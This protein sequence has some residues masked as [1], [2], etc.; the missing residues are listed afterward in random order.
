MIY[1]VPIGVIKDTVTKMYPN[2]LMENS[3]RTICHL[4]FVILFYQF[5][6]Y[7]S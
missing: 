7:L 5:F 4:P 3:D 1:F 6:F 2:I